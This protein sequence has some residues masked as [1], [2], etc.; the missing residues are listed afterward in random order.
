[1][2]HRRF[3]NAQLIRDNR[4]LT[5]HL[6]LAAAHIRRLSLDNHHLRRALDTSSNITPLGTKPRI[7]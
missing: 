5:E 6:D 2:S 7:R 1:M 3:I 4:Q